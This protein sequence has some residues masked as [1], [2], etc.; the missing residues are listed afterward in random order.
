[1]QPEGDSGVDGDKEK[2]DGRAK[3]VKV[4]TIII[5]LSIASIAMH[6][7]SCLLYLSAMLAGKQGGG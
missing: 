3:P 4:S 2:D 6:M 1:M 7:K 5:L